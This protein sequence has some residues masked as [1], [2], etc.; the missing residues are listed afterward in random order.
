MT[1]DNDRTE[2]DSTGTLLTMNIEDIDEEL[3]VEYDMT[4]IDEEP[5]GSSTLGI[6]CS[7]GEKHYS[8][9]VDRDN[10]TYEYDEETGEECQAAEA[11]MPN[12]IYVKGAVLKFIEDVINE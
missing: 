8:T 2:D 3:I 4:D 5:G 12:A 7:C 10:E 11:V 9:E 6:I 1:V